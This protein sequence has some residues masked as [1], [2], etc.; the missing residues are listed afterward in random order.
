MNEALAFV[1]VGIWDGVFGIWVWDFSFW[2]CAWG[3]RWKR[4]GCL[5][6]SMRGRR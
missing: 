6:E 5:K 4:G 1:C 2:G 3:E